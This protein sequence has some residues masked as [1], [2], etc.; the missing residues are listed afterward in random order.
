MTAGEDGQIRL[1]VAVC[2]HNPRLPYLRQVLQALE[3]QT[4]PFQDW[5]LLVIDNMSDQAVREM[6]SIAWHPRARWL[7]EEQ[8]GITQARLCALRSARSDLVIFVDDDNLLCSNYLE[9]ALKIHSN[10]PEVGVFGAGVIEPDFEVPPPPWMKDFHGYLAL[11]TLDQTHIS[12]APSGG[13]RPWGPGLCVGKEVSRIYIQASEEDL[14]IQKIGRKQKSLVSG[15]DDM[16]AVL[17]AKYG[18]KYGVFPDL[19]V[20]HLIP[21]ERLDL[22]YFK[23]LVRGHAHS[24]AMIATLQGLSVAN[25]FMIPSWKAAFALLIAGHPRLAF[26]QFRSFL[27]LESQPS[28]VFQL[29]KERC[30]GWEDGAQM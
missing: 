23:R 20:I 26:Q 29:W 17:G 18:V 8:L 28:E 13:Y 16:F 15:D 10:Y 1:S 21:K 24:H 7:Y 25:P 2:T 30:L 3:Q 22:E 11:R 27:A 6:V 19:K 14:R 5:E 9:N 12:G 4:L